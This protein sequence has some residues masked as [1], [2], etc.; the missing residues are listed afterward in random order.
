RRHHHRRLDRQRACVASTSRHRTLGDVR[1]GPRVA[2]GLRT[3][4]RWRGQACRGVAGSVVSV[5]TV[6]DASSPPFPGERT[7]VTIGAYDGL[8]IG[9]QAVIAQV[10][11]LAAERGAR[12]GVVTFD[13]HPASVVRPESAP[14]LL[15]DNDQRLELLSAT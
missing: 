3:V 1:T 8:H 7:V 2:G 9:H 6:T 5:L 15:T 10:R 4:R 13:R 11:A 12:S 14:K